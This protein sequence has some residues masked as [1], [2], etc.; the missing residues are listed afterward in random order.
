MAGLLRRRA[1]SSAAASPGAATV[2]LQGLT[3]TFVRRG[4]AKVRALDDVSLTVAPGEFVVLL[5]PSG[6]G[7]TTLLRCIA[8][9]E[10]ADSGTID[11][12]GVRVFAGE[13]RHNVAP[14]AR[15]LNMMFQ[16][17][18]L[19]PHMTVADNVGFPL[20]SKKVPRR[21]VRQR[22]EEILATDRDLRVESLPSGSVERWSAATCRAWRGR[23]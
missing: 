8:G 11:I 7:K 20:R 17:Y 14:N 3:K 22:V 2:E 10:A 13:R 5:G 9:L 15:S 16:S 6:C 18:A 1:E 23:W 4:G 19:W 21:E 12:C